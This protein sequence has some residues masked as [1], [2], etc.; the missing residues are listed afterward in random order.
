[1]RKDF[2]KV[3]DLSPAAWNERYSQGDTPW[4]LSGP[5]PEFQ[6]LLDEGA[7]PAKGRVLVPGGGRGH[8]AIL[9]AQRKYEVDLVD[10]APAAIEAALQEASR[11]KAVV[12]AYRQNFFDLSAVGYH[13]AAYDILLEYTFFCAIAPAERPRYAAAAAQLVK[14]GGLLVGLFFPLKMNKLGPPFEVSE[15]EVRKLFAPHFEVTISKPHA[16]VKPRAGN[17]FLGLLRKK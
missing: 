3:T 7:L 16:S 6:R 5:T 12:Y 14:P 15:A 9:F 1:L 2:L 13:Q 8:D 4:D 17:E 10:F 11:A